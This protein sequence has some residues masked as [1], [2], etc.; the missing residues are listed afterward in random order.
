MPYGVFVELEKGVEGLVHISE[1][2][3]SKK[4][5]HPN[6]LLKLGDMVEAIVLDM[7]KDNRK[8]SLGIKQ[9]EKDPWIGIESNYKVGD[10]VKGKVISLT[11]YGAFV[12]IE[13]GVDGLVHVS[14]IS[15]TK[16]ITHPKD[17]LKKDADIETI[18]FPWMRRTG[19]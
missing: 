2:S 15:W 10:K 6:E 11:D 14:D 9:L 13:K 4:Y 7:D 5:N 12:E 16:K 1:L 18:F 17:V 19:A 3:W 8:I